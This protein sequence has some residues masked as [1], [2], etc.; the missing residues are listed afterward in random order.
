MPIL[1]QAKDALQDYLAC[2]DEEVQHSKGKLPYFGDKE[3]RVL[4]S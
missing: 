1:P 2:V 4:F 3:V